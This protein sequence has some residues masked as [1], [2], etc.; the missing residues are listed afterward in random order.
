MTAEQFIDHLQLLPHPE[1]GFYK[2]TY[3]SASVIPK[4]TIQPFTEERNVST[5]IYFL[6]PS[7]HISALHKILSDELWFFHCGTSLLIHSFDKENGVKTHRLGFD[8]EKG[9]MPCRMISAHSWF[10]A[11]VEAENSYSLVSCTVAPGFD[12]NDFELG[13]RE[14][15]IK[16][17][18]DHQDLIHRLT[19]QEI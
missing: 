5:A 15:L 6:L 3:R 11:E 16:E 19:H 4:G 17:F 1:G 8:I 18:P 7:G 13:K 2:E 14:I 10:G 12:F 9:D